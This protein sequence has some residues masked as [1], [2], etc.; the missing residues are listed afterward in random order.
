MSSPGVPRPRSATEIFD[1]SVRLVRRHY[2]PMVAL[3]ALFYVP[4]AAV[5]TVAV[6]SLVPFGQPGRVAPMSLAAIAGWTAFSVVWYHATLGVALTLAAADAYGGIDVQLPASLRGMVQRLPGVLAL[7]LLELCVF[8]LAALCWALPSVVFVALGLQLLPPAISRVTIVAV[9]VALAIGIFA[10]TMAALVAA[11]PVLV[12]ERMGARASLRRSLQLTK[13]LRAHVVGLIG[14]AYLF[15]L[16]LYFG[17]GAA[18]RLMGHPILNRIGSATVIVMLFPFVQVPFLLL[19][20]DLRV[21][22]E[23]YD[24]EVMAGALEASAAPQV[25]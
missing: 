22:K 25:A 19:Y 16:G 18:L 21:R 6:P 10:Y 13:G 17:V 11:L 14:L 4:F 8:V 23:G 7:S 1:A 3:T 5:Q 9:P 15:Y 20:Y 2:G 24:I 12:L